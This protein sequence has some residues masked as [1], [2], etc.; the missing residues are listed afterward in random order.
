MI[1]ITHMAKKERNRRAEAERNGEEGHKVRGAHQDMP[2]PVVI[3][4][5]VAGMG[6]GRIARDQ[7]DS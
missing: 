5:A 6:M 7:G 4:E 3:A 1:T 2:Q